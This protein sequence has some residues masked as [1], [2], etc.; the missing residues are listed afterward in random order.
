M[1]SLTPLSLFS[2]IH[3]ALYLSN[4]LK[5]HKPKSMQGDFTKSLHNPIKSPNFHLFQPS[6]LQLVPTLLHPEFAYVGDHLSLKLYR[7]G[8]CLETQENS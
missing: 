7:Y 3:F 5:T 8:D 6:L 1:G 4:T 2:N